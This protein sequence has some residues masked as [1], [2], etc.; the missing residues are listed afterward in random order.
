M[1]EAGPPDPRKGIYVFAS[2]RKG[3]GKSVVCRM[4]FDAYPL[5]RI[6]V[7]PTHDLRADFRREGVEFDELD[8]DALPAR[9]PRAESREDHKRKTWVFC[10]DMG[11][12][13]CVDDMDRV[14]GLALGRGPTL[15]WVDEFGTLTTATKVPPNTRRVLHHGR[16]DGLTFLC[17][18]PRPKD[19]AGLAINQADKVYTFRTPNP[20]DRERIAKNIAYDPA[21]FD[22]INESLSAPGRGKHWHT[23]Y[24]Q[25]ADELWI[26]PPLPMRRA[27]RNP[28]VAEPGDL[29]PLDQAAEADELHTA[30]RNGR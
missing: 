8:A 6:V 5:D 26:M 18:C 1:G 27:G 4:W 29:A 2:G 13:T 14:V 17:A 11:S 16:H 20:D 19:I 3:S 21:E 12:P 10:P 15:L 28:R 9:L 24:D 7:D 23:M 22:R 25:E 30:A